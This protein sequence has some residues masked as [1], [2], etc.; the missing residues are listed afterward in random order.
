MTQSLNRVPGAFAAAP[1][2][3]VKALGTRLSVSNGNNAR[4]R[5]GQRALFGPE[6]L[7][8]GAR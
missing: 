8:T 2:F 5:D 4:E 7:L 6:N 1:N 3:K